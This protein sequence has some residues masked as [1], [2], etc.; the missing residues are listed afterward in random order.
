MQVTSHQ[1]QVN[2]DFNSVEEFSVPQVNK[3]NQDG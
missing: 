3:I 1:Y 2:L